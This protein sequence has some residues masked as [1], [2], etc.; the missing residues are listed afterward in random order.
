MDEW[1]I[2][3]CIRGYHVYKSVWA[4]VVAEVLLCSRE[5]TNSADRCAV[6]VLKNEVVI[7]HIPRK[8]SPC[9]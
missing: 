7:G 8:I 4:A 6:A 1:E 9:S 3:S 2:P 5:L